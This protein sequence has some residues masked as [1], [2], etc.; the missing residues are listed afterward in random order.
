MFLFYDIIG[1]F[2][3]GKECIATFD[4]DIVKE[5]LYGLYLVCLCIYLV[6][7]GREVF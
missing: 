1:Q 4:G 5:G 2:P 7:N 6:E 3:L